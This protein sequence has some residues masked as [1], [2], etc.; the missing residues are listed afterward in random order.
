MRHHYHC[1]KVVHA[2][3]MVAPLIFMWIYS[4]SLILI[5]EESHPAMPS[6]STTVDW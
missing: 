3:E 6:S 2:I 4:D 5:M 1:V